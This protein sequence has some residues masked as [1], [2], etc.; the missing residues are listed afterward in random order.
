LTTTL[1]KLANIAEECGELDIECESLIKCFASGAGMQFD[2]KNQDPISANPT[3][4]LILATNN[5]PRFKDRTDGI[6]RRIILVPFNRRVPDEERVEG[7]DKPEWWQASGELPGIFNWALA[8][9]IRLRQRK[10][11]LVP[12]IC[13]AA[14]EDYK[15]ETNPARAYLDQNIIPNSLMALATMELYENYKKWCNERNYRPLGER[16]FGKEVFRAFPALKKTRPETENNGRRWTY[17]GIT[18]RP[19]F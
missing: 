15:F 1:G 10:D 16:V 6:W 9:L 13:R 14:V 5:R 19:D 7:M 2:R 4:R 17:E 8:G 11:F 12:E 18:F 3:A